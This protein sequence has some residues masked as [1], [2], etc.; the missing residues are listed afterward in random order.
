[1]QGIYSKINFISFT[2]SLIGGGIPTLKMN[3]VNQDSFP[4]ANGYAR[5]IENL[6]Q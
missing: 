4:Q 1:M 6:A 3:F 2:M 5:A